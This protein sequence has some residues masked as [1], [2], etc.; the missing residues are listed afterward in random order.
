VPD[1]EAGMA[2]IRRWLRPGGGLAVD[3]H[4]GNSPLAAAL[5]RELHA[6]AAGSVL[7]AYRTI[8][9]A[10]LAALPQEGH[11]A[12][13][14]AGAAQVVPLLR[15]D[16]DIQYEHSRHV[17]LDHYPLLYYL[18]HDKDLYAYRH[19]LAI[20]NQIQTWLA[21]ADPAGGEYV[22]IVAANRAPV[23]NDDEVSGIRYQV[24]GDDV[25][26]PE[27]ANTQHATRNT[28]HA[29]LNSELAQRVAELEAALAAQGAWARS[30]EAAVQTRERELA[31][32][33]GHLR[34]V[35]NGRVMRLLRRL[36]GGRGR[37]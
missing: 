29:T 26:V 9:D 16:F 14:D 5:G 6:W 12:L 2:D 34:R 25:A 17:V 31:R 27:K 13:E 33:Q 10:D 3:E 15:R 19:S 21:A 23:I 4:V 36:G 28:Q 7:P 18:A 30:L 37:R 1:L 32:V 11:S 35:E 20:A 24:S 22:T 8:P